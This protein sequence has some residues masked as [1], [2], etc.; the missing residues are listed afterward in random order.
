MTS[1]STLAE[2]GTRR[3]EGLLRAV[4][5]TGIG[6]W[7]P[8]EVF[9]RKSRQQM[10]ALGARAAAVAATTARAWLDDCGI[11]GAWA[12]GSYQMP[13]TVPIAAKREATFAFCGMAR[14]R[15]VGMAQCEATGAWVARWGDRPD[16]G[17]DPVEEVA[18]I[19]DRVLA[20]TGIHERGDART[21]VA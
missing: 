2:L 8:A 5:T 12:R 7:I 4:N 14:T 10:M 3:H 6:V 19:I 21:V 18:C 17:R 20:A 11:E 1:S 15:P 16:D 9:A 13:T